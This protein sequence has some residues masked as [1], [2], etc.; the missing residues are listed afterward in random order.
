[1]QKY[2]FIIA[3]ITILSFAL[4]SWPITEK[5]MEQ[6]RVIAAKA[7]LRYA[8][9]GSGYLDDIK[10]STMSELQSKLKP[11]ELENLKTFNSVKVPSDYSSWDKSKLTEFWGSTFFTS[12]NLADKG[13]QAKST[14]RRRIA[15]LLVDDKKVETP[16]EEEK[17]A[18]ETE[19]APTE[20]EPVAPTATVEKPDTTQLLADQQA[21]ADDAANSQELKKDNG[22]TWIFTIILIVLIGVV[23]W[24]V[25]FAANIMKRQ[26]QE[27]SNSD[28]YD[29]DPQPE[30]PR[31]RE[32]AAAQPV[33]MPVAAN[34]EIERELRE[35]VR[36]LDEE[37]AQLRRQLRT[38]NEEATRLHTE[39]ENARALLANNARQ[40]S[41]ATPAR[42]SEASAAPARN[43]PNVVYLGR[44]NRDGIFV[45]ADRRIT[46]GATIYRL[47]TRD[48]LVGTFHVVDEP[49]IVDFA[50]TN[51][52]E[53]L[54]HGCASNEDLLDTHGV[55]RIITD[56]AGT[57]LFEEGRWKVLRK[58]RIRY[59]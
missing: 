31:R 7:Y 47:D 52:A 9:D 22:E 50:L 58:S 4:P 57:A 6:A 46:P 45:R 56:N 40:Q 41:Q 37:N 26:G 32:S 27:K 2:R 13:K 23:I 14:V 11:K 3:L 16:A 17:P 35:Q 51:P 54:G 48:G 33:S 21:V 25:V 49:E 44:V 20:S 24:L 42:T 1:M 59:E 43:M 39:L 18:E 36:L 8:N 30:K 28:N 29:S 55:S 38:A 15:E 34:N 10:A 53:Y 12:P 5:E 19:P